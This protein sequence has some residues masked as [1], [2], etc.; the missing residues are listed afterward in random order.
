[1]Q[2]YYLFDCDLTSQISEQTHQY[3]L[4]H[5]ALL[6]AAPH[7]W[8]Q[9]DLREL[10]AHAPAL[11]RFCREHRLLPASASAVIF[12][13]ELFVHVDTPPVVAKVNFPVC[14]TE[15]YENRWYH[16]PKEDIAALPTRKDGLGQHFFEF[17]GVEL[18]NYP[19]STVVG[20]TAPMVL[21]SEIPHGVFAVD[22][23]ETPQR[24]LLSMTFHNEP[25]HL[26]EL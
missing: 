20:M 10:L 15:Y 7:P 4:D 19:V 12:T 9:L 2:P 3:L 21:N 22:P 13:G 25:L 11:M 1:M 24:V 8:N 23:A 6:D 16:I 14:N 18:E 26:L 17:R 5:T